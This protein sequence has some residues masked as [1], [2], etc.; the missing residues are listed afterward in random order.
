MT[1]S[2]AAPSVNPLLAAWTGPFGLPPFSEIRPEHFAPALAHAMRQHLAELDAIGAQPDEPTFDNTVAALD[3]A[4]ALLYRL[5]AVLGNLTAS[6]TSPALQ[7]VQRDMAAPLAAHDTAVK[8]HAGVFR[9]LN[10]LHARRHEL[11]LSPEAQRL[12]ERLHDDAVRSGARFNPGAQARYSAI[13]QEQA[14]LTTRFAQNVL[15]DESSYLL[16]LTSEADL[17]GLPDFV[18]AA[19]R[20]AAAERGLPAGSHVVTLNRSLIVPFLT[21]SERRDLRE[22]AWRAWVGRGESG[23]PTDNRAL[24]RQILQLRQQQAAAHGCTCYADYALADT[25]A[26]N[27]AEVRKLLHEV[28]RRA[29]PAAERERQALVAMMRTHQVDG[30]PQ[31]WDWRYWSEK[32]RQARY[33]IDEAELKPYFSLDNMV[34]ALFDCAQRLFGVRFEARP[35]IQAYHPDV[36]AYEMFD[37]AGRS[38]GLFLQDNF[39]RQSKR[40]GAWMSDFNY[41]SRN[42]GVA[43]PIIVNNNNFAKAAPGEPTLLSFDDARTLFHEFGHGL[44]GLLSNVTYH[45]L[46]GTQVLRDFVE[47]PSQ[48]FEHWLSQPEVLARH[49]RHWQ[50]GE[51]IPQALID[52]L[53]AAQRWG[54]G[55][56]T[57]S[58]LGSALVDLA[59]HA[60]TNLQ[61]LDDVSAFEREELARLGMPPALGVRHRLVHFQHLFAG[62]SYA[63]GYYVYL[64]AEVL[65]ADAFG[66]F[67]EV[68]NPFDAD[69]AAR[70]HRHIYSVGDSVP[71]QQAYTDF[72][73]RLPALEP[74]LSKRGLLEGENLPVG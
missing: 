39:A 38:A 5:E 17:A 45:R 1:H 59:L 58:Y 51:P 44:H 12:L 28:W 62:S 35:A 64:W 63:C 40:S 56:D 37:A 3:R 26:G 18:R 16:P 11:G 55:Y 27:Q 13:M 33:A 30:E 42:R 20:Q 48:L 21:F 53:Q 61:G 69:V 4:G 67:E 36:K 24:A 65:D 70:L 10:A 34:Q 2:A 66:A 57:V 50:T 71:P 46:A 6:E 23:G 73:G 54:Q 19:A 41:Q 49:A 47:L 52:R 7:A 32:V 29:L 68:G 43:A 15:A 22:Q 25:M 72:R 60:Q 14:T 31:A 8:M 74:L 9:R